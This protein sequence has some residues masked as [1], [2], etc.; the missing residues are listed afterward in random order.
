MDALND[1]IFDQ[2]I[3][4]YFDAIAHRDVDGWLALMS[5]SV[6]L[7]EPAGAIPAQTLEGAKETW[8]VLTSAFSDLRFEIDA[9]HVSGSGAATSWR[10]HAVGVNDAHG[11]AAGITVFEFDAEGLIETVVS[12]WDP[13]ALLIALATDDQ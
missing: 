1:P 12:Y 4:R 9:I 13:A 5:A 8:K 11:Q 2:T 10:C 3:R 6:T 7:H